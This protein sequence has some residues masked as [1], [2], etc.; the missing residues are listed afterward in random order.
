MSKD[1]WGTD[2]AWDVVTPKS[3]SQ[4]DV[5]VD[6]TPQLQGNPWK[7]LDADLKRVQKILG[8]KWSYDSETEVFRNTASRPWFT[9][10]PET[11]QYHDE[12]EGIFYDWNKYTENFEK[13]AERKSK[14]FEY[15][16]NFKRSLKEFL[17]HVSDRGLPRTQLLASVKRLRIRAEKSYKNK[18]SRISISPKLEEATRELLQELAGSRTD[19]TG[20][21]VLVTPPYTCPLCGRTTSDPDTILAHVKLHEY[22]S[23]HGLLSAA[24]KKDPNE[25]VQRLL[26]SEAIFVVGT[27]DVQTAVE[28]AVNKTGANNRKR[29]QAYTYMK[30]WLGISEHDDFSCDVIHAVRAAFPEAHGC[31]SGR[32]NCQTFEE[33]QMAED[34]VVEIPCSGGVFG[35]Q[36]NKNFEHGSMFTRY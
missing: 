19:T 23:K 31:Y 8:V 20:K 25:A 15:V 32:H 22:C 7:E 27:K 21:K 9:F 13:A 6:L 36:D 34:S 2:L 33:Q 26:R 10:S 30:Q 29:Y 28:M 11:N 18:H 24:A 5:Y 35:N 4:N 16:Q 12:K 17:D 3:S 1:A 14:M